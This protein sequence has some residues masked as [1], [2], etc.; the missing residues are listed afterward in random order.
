MACFKIRKIDAENCCFKDEWTVHLIFSK[1]VALI[2][3]PKFEQRAHKLTELKALYI[4][5][6]RLIT[7][8]FT[9]QQHKY[10]CSLKVLWILGQKKLFVLGPVVKECLNAVS[11]TLFEGKQKKIPISD[12]RAKK[13]IRNS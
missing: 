6:T 9:A 12:S 10:K 7:K 8:T 2:N 1:T 5:S 13:K 11:E 4:R 3:L